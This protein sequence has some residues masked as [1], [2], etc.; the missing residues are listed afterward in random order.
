MKMKLRITSHDSPVE[1][2]SVHFMFHSHVSFKIFM[3]QGIL[4][5]HSC[6]SFALHL[7]VKNCLIG[8]VAKYGVWPGIVRAEQ[9][10]LVQQ[11]KEN[12]D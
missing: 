2:S 4:H 1:F 12:D 8:H 10:K 5:S 3:V 6:Q 9:S 11:D 7:D